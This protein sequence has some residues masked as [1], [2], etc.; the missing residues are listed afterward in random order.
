MIPVLTQ[1]LKEQQAYIEA[2][3]KRLTELEKTIN[4]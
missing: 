1:A 3:E 2:L 4:E